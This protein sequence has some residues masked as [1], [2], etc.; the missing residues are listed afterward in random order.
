MKIN[1]LDFTT[2]RTKRG[3]RKDPQQTVQMPTVQQSMRDVKKELDSLWD[4]PDFDVKRA[5]YLEREYSRLKDLEESGELYDVP[6]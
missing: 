5:D 1:L 3:P 4:K 2:E 6:F